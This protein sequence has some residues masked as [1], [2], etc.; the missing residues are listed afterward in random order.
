MGSGLKFSS[1]HKF[2]KIMRTEMLDVDKGTSDSG[3][4]APAKP[5]GSPK[6]LIP[7]PETW[8]KNT[9]FGEGWV[10]RKANEKASDGGP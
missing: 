3:V 7:G 9:E 6:P 8:A 2:F 1:E 5:E 4:V 10:A